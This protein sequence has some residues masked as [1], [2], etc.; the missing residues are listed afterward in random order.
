MMCKK[1]VSM[2]Y[3]ILV[4]SALVQEYRKKDF[5]QTLMLQQRYK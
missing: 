2:K 5:I 3:S 1:I 4:Y